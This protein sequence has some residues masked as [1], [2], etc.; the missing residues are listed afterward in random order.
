MGQSHF[1][2]RGQ[3]LPQ[4]EATGEVDR[5]SPSLGLGKKRP[6]CITLK[7]TRQNNWKEKSEEL[8]KILLAGG[9]CLQEGEKEMWAVQPARG[10]NS[11]WNIY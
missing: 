8:G 7:P 1:W 2:Q 4:K 6:R 11:P 3:D 9:V 5:K 10:Q